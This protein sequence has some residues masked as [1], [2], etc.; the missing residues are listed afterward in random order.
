RAPPTSRSFL[1]F[2][3]VAPR[4]AAVDVFVLAVGSPAP[5]FPSSVPRP[6][7]PTG[8]PPRPLAVARRVAVARR[9]VPVVK[10]ARGFSPGSPIRALPAIAATLIVDVAAR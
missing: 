8:P 7:P 6:R 9:I 4:I 2:A 10:R 5:P 3:P 1:L